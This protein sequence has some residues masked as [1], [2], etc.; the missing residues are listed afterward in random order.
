MS[1]AAEV[2][3]LVIG[4]GVAGLA[5]ATRVVAAGTP[6]V[7]VE[8]ADR[9]GGKAHTEHHEGFLIEAGPDS[10]VSYRPAAI[11][12][13]QELGLG[14]DIIST[15]D[16][17]TVHLRRAGE[18]VPMPAGMGMV[19]PTQFAPFVRTELFSWPQKFR[20]G[21][22][23]VMPRRL[24]PGDISIGDFLA[25][26]LGPGLV[27]RLAEPMLGGVYGASV[28]DLSLDAVLPQLRDY[29]NQ[30]RS[31]L[32]AALRQGQ[33]ARTAAAGRSAA[34]STGASPFRSL[35]DGM[36][37][38]V[39]A[40][41]THCATSGLAD[42]RAGVSVTSLTA[43]PHGTVA[44]LSDGSQVNAAAV[45]F[46]T[47]AHVTAELIAEHLPKAAA[48]MKSG[49]RGSTAV[50]SLAYREEAF[51]VPPTGHGFLEA[52][53]NPAVFSGVTFSSRKWVGRAP[54]GTVLLR[55]FLPSRSAR[56]AM[57]FDD[58]VVAAVHEQLSAILGIHEKPVVRSVHR[59]VEAMPTY[60]VGHLDRMTALDRATS[61]RPD[62]ALAGASYRGV[63]VPDCVASGRSAGDAVLTHVHTAA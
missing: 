37:S 16:P 6:V 59:W 54:A 53:P 13:A 28:Y 29:E 56:L 35:R 18:M 23:V 21:L 8:A 25:E 38:L 17:R 55:A 52:G 27:D 12:W 42:L 43:A 24:P 7:V 19:L 11:T 63:G 39:T 45:V 4:G 40:A 51:D 50:V 34:G 22:D 32:I 5:A 3:V 10:F 47:P 61:V 26:R 14:A 48:I 57:G 44:N 33:Q 62:W 36:G 58:E 20:A 49:V 1:R 2:P 9:W 15:T 41:V 60:T 30:H 46:A 31:L